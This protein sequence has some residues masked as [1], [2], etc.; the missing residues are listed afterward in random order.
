M[1]PKSNSP[2]SAASLNP[3]T[4]CRAQTLNVHDEDKT[5]NTHVFDIYVQYSQQSLLP[6]CNNIISFSSIQQ[7][8]CWFILSYQSWYNHP[9]LQLV[10][11]SSQVPRVK[12]AHLYFIYPKHY[13]H[14]RPLY[15][16]CSFIYWLY[17]STE[18]LI[19]NLK[20][21]TILNTLVALLSCGG[22]CPQI[23]E[24]S[25]KGQSS[26]PSLYCPPV[27]PGKSL[28]ESSCYAECQ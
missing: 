20:F 19:K 12:R 1:H 4:F 6:F 13:I 24:L 25:Y 16:L 9:I 26:I 23:W 22:S 21:S 2:R 10:D 7:L 18:C 5:P 28:I 27:S 11:C 15:W 3:G 17:I 14:V 8:Y